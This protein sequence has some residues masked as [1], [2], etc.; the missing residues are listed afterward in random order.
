MKNDQINIGGV[1][2]FRCAQFAKRQNDP[3][4]LFHRL[5][6]WRAFAP[7]RRL[8]KQ[9]TNC[10][11]NCGLCGAAEPFHLCGDIST[12]AIPCA[13]TCACACACTQVRQSHGERTALAKPA[14]GPHHGG[15]ISDHWRCRRQF[16]TGGADDC[17]TLSPQDWYNGVLVPPRQRLKMVRMHQHGGKC[18]C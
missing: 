9:V 18:V 3:A 6:L 8:I 1:I 10:G 15:V 4:A 13:M 2:Q 11:A 5:S 14:K 17:G 12:C 7:P 16:I